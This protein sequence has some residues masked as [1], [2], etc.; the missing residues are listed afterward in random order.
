MPGES[1]AETVE[2]LER[3]RRAYELRMSGMK[4]E[5][6]ATHPDIEAN[7]GSAVAA[8]LKREQRRHTSPLVHEAR[9]L[10]A[11]RLDALQAVRW[12]QA[13]EGS[14]AAIEDVLAIMRRRAQLLGLD[15]KDVLS[16]KRLALEEDRV[17]FIAFAFTKAMEAVQLRG[18]DRQ[19]AAQAFIVSLQDN[20]IIGT[21]AELEA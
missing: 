8:M 15:H 19:R 10:E 14:P 9:K 12:K 5:D 6:I 1:T 16:S 17:R 2:R 7:S 13:M 4:L 11:D 20:G 3:D 18:E 21:F